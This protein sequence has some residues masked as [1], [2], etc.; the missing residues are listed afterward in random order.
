MKK[1]NFALF[2]LLSLNCFS[3]TFQDSIILLNGKTFRGNI[4]EMGGEYLT[5]DFDAKKGV[6]KLM[7]ENYR[8]YSYTKNGAETILYKHDSLSSNFLTVDQ[9]RNF[10]LGSYDARQTYKPKAIFYSSIALTLGLS[11]FD[12]YLF[13]SEAAKIETIVAKPGFF[14]GRPSV[15]PLGMPFVLGISYGLTNIKVKEKYILQKQLKNDSFYYHGFNKVSKEK[16]T[17]AALKGSAIGIGL[18]LISYGIL[19]INDY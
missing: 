11:L 7:L 1:I 2:A 8:I 6:E 14:G 3:Q 4:L 16:R 12:T 15:I 9:S 13:K 19:K 17:F 5:F 10:T 18:G